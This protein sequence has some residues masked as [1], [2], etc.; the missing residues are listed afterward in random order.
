MADI[1]Y[2]FAEMESAAVEVDGYVDQYKQAAQT[3]IESLN[4]IT[5]KWEGES[6]DKFISL[7]NGAVQEYIVDSIPQI[8]SVIAAEIR[9]S[10][11]N[12]SQTDASLAENIPQTLG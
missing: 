4:S 9:Q 11:E 12:M 2:R 8:V 1:T 7:V 10:S 6:K 5:S 3:L